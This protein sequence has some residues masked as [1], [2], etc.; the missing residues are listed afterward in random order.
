MPAGLNSDRHSMH[1]SIVPARRRSFLLPGIILLAASLVP[2]AQ[3]A[4]AQQGY[5]APIAGSP[6]LGG[7]NKPRDDVYTQAMKL[8]QKGQY[9]EAVPI[10]ESMAIQGHGFEIA[11]LELGRCYYDLSRQPAASADTA[12]RQRIQGFAW[13]LA[14]ANAGFGLAE[15][16]MVRIYLDGMG[17]PTDRWEAGKWY[18]LWRRNPSRMQIGTSQFDAGLEARLKAKLSAAD[19]KEAQQRAD[20]WH[21]L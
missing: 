10:L 5:Q 16:E 21:M 4:R 17:V 13:I 14:A 8:K 11:Q 18:L 20:Q 15:Q 3:P 1:P 9:S 12:A 6:S 2:T 7:G 19:W